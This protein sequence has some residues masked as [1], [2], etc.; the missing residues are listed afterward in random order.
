MVT[1][2]SPVHRL[3]HIVQTHL[4]W[5]VQMFNLDRPCED[6][7]TAEAQQPVPPPPPP[8]NPP[9][10]AATVAGVPL[11]EPHSHRQLPVQHSKSMPPE[12]SPDQAVDIG[13]KEGH[14]VYVCT[15]R[16]PGAENS[17]PRMRALL[18]QAGMPPFDAEYNQNALAK[19]D[20]HRHKP[21]SRQA[22]GWVPEKKHKADAA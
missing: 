21:N 1:Y 8:G 9:E 13:V 12:M 16:A 15:K 2:G 18:E 5:D 11:H 17:S 10:A 3:Q 20:G 22:S 14:Y 4:N 6:S 7:N 19:T